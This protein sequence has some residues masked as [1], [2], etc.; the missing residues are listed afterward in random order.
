MTSRPAAGPVLYDAP[1]E[2]CMEPNHLSG[3]A[4]F[5][6]DRAI[7]ATPPR[8]RDGVTWATR[9]DWKARCEA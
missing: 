8:A 7:D 2:E 6:V 3:R 1:Q 4:R 9:G 5:P